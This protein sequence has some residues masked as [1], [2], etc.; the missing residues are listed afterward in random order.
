MTTTRYLK[1]HTAPLTGKTVAVTG[2]TGGLGK[3]LCRHLAALGASLWLL[4]RNSQKSN[5][6]IDT[7]KAEFPA[8]SATHVCVDMADFASVQR[9][10]EQLKQAPPDVLILNAGAYHIP[11]KIC[12]TGLDNVFQINFASPYYMARTLRPA[13]VQKGGKVVAVASIAHNYS[14]SDP[15]DVDFAGRTKPSRVYGNAKRYLMAAL[16]GLFKAEGG[17]AVTHPGITFTGITAHYPKLIFALIKH[18]MKLIFMP[19]RKASLCILRGV[20]E[21]TAACEWIGPRA[22]SIWGLP[23]KKR[24]LTIPPAEQT[25]IC[26]AAEKIYQKLQQKGE[27]L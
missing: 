9:V 22:F 25:Q 21:D 16:W 2:A 4:D 1:K 5:A 17:L 19:P 18:P 10:T 6:L 27:A 8:L 14:Q 23:K 20:F 11:R 15:S 7:L 12:D 26:A 3:A 24:L 13:L